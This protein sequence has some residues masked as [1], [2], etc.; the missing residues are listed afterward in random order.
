MA[1]VFDLDGESSFPGSN[2]WGITAYAERFS[3][4]SVPMK[5]FGAYVYFVKNDAEEVVDL[6]LIHI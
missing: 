5:V 6:S 2:K 1:T 4:P 3:A